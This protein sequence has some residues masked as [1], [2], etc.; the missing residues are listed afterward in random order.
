M[1]PIA[2][3]TR[4]QKQKGNGLQTEEYEDIKSKIVNGLAKIMTRTHKSICRFLDKYADQIAGCSQ[5]QLDDLR[6][7]IKPFG[8]GK[9]I[10]DMLSKF[11]LVGQGGMAHHLAHNQGITAR[12]FSLLVEEDKKRLNKGSVLVRKRGRTVRVEAEK[13]EPHDLKRIIAK[14]GK[15]YRI[16][17]P[18]NQNKRSLAKT[19]RNGGAHCLMNGWYRDDTDAHHPIVLVGVKNGRETKIRTDI[20]TLLR[21]VDEIRSS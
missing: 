11:W 3:A 17:P 20:E 6:D 8:I 9:D 10:G 21:F 2:A 4:T 12:K 14:D 18:E 7:A 5:A 16:L 15:R 19:V 13:L 1:F